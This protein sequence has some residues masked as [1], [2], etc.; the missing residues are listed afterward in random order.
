M[1]IDRQRR[2][3]ATSSSARLGSYEPDCCARRRERRGRPVAGCSRDFRGHAD[4]AAGHQAATPR[5][6]SAVVGA[7]PGRVRQPQLAARHAGRHLRSRVRPVMPLSRRWLWLVAAVALALSVR[8]VPRPDL[9]RHQTRPHRQP[10]AVPGPGD[11]S[12][13]Q[14]AAVRPGA[15]P[16]LRL[17]VSARHV[18][19]GRPPAGAARLDHPAA[20][21]GAAVDGRLLGVAAGRRGAGHRQPDVAR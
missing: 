19:L 3:A 5:G 13:E 1:A 16:G 10:A 15:E 20:V 11:Q 6:R 7:Q 4:G 21:V 12:V 14:R 9:A 17:P 8:A 18:L 2:P